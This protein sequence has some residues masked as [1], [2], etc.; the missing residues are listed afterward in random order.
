M[1]TGAAAAHEFGRGRQPGEMVFVPSTS[2][3]H[4]GADEDDGYLLGYV[5]DRAEDRSDLV[6]LA[7][8]DIGAEPLATVHL[9]RRVPDARVAQDYRYGYAVSSGDDSGL[10]SGGGSA[11]VRYDMT[12]GAAAAHE[13]GRGRQPGEMVF[14]PSTSAGHGGDED[15]G[16][17]L[18]YVYDPTNGSKSGGDIIEWG[19]VNRRPRVWSHWP[20]D[21]RDDQGRPLDGGEM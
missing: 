17:L 19:Y 5:Y 6:I 2:A 10:T 4:E 13:F 7:A 3:G 20:V 14:V 1:T 11:V 8:G 15:D 9:P 16:Y 18:G 21:V 12:T